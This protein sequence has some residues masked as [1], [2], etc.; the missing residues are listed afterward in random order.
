MNKEKLSKITNIAV[1]ILLAILVWQSF[2]PITWDKIQD[3]PE[4]AVDGYYDYCVEWGGFIQR[5]E[6]LMK[7]YDFKAKE[8]KCTWWFNENKSVTF[9]DYSNRTNIIA[10]QE[11]TK[12]VKSIDIGK[13]QFV[14][15]ENVE[16]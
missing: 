1:M 8:I 14:I 15:K 2:Q 3:K 11:C 5:E 16:E 6:L 4:A 10:E 13:P 7:C 9:Y 12:F